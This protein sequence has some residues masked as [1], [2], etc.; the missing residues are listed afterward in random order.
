M[1]ASL[2]N[3]YC[4]TPSLSTSSSPLGSD[5]AEAISVSITW[6]FQLPKLTCLQRSVKSASCTIDVL[7][8]ENRLTE[9]LA[10][11]CAHN[12]G[13]VDC[14]LWISVEFLGTIVQFTS[15]FLSEFRRAVA[16]YLRHSWRSHSVWSKDLPS[17]IGSSVS[18]SKKAVDVLGESGP[19]IDGNST[20]NL[21]TAL[22]EHQRHVLEAVL[23][24][25][26]DQIAAAQKALNGLVGAPMSEELTNCLKSVLRMKGWRVRC[27][28][29]KAAMFFWSSNSRHKLGG[30]ARLCH[31]GK[32]PHV[33]I[34]AFR[35][36]RLLKKEGN[37]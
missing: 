5:P 24:L 34:S 8:V 4:M 9:L 12:D 2:T 31:H 10:S 29:S 1:R 33:T 26:S 28:C 30:A 14:D 32:S 7:T 11:F 22:P 21:L 36:I 27:T 37:G 6:G 3:P 16:E 13:L 18:I 25:K 23:K 15:P 20:L 35:K 19:R 17:L